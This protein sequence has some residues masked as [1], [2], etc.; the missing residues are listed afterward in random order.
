MSFT[1]T[2]PFFEKGAISSNKKN[3]KDAAKDIWIKFSRNV[4]N[5][6]PNFYFS[7]K[8]EE[9]GTYQH[10]KVSESISEGNKVAMRIKKLTKDKVNKKVLDAF[11]NKDSF[12]EES[13]VNSMKGGEKKYKKHDLNND[14]DD[15]DDSD[16]SDSDSSSDDFKIK[17]NRRKSKGLKLIY[18]PGMYNVPLIGLPLISPSVVTNVALWGINSG[19]SAGV[20]YPIF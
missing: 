11:V 9:E 1:L 10:F 15:D 18:T 20:S 7:I 8:N 19:Y 6:T 12:D 13:S 5:Y 14:D 3:E 16:S 4:K 17:K 2:N